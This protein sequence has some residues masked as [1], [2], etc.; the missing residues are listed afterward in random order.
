MSKSVFEIASIVA[1]T[2]KSFGILHYSRQSS[3]I[4][5]ICTD[6][7]NFTAGH[8]V[9]AAVLLAKLSDATDCTVLLPWVYNTVIKAN[10]G[11]T[12]S[13]EDLRDAIHMVQEARMFY[14]PPTDDSLYI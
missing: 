1:G 8:T 10:R 4:F 11:G 12:L 14:V 2:D 7:A 5:L 9:A 13:A 6:V 3:T